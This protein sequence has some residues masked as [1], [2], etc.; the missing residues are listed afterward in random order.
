MAASALLGLG[1]NLGDRRAILRR[2]LAALAPLGQVAATSPVYETA[3]RAVVDQP[4][5]LNMAAELLTD[6][7]PLDL[8]HALKAIEGDLGRIP[9]PRFGPRSIDLD[10]LLFADQVIDLPALQVPHPRLAERAFALRPLADI[11][12]ARRHPLLGKTVAQL[13]AEIGAEQGV[14]R[15]ADQP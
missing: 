14:L 7:L 9:G 1:G 5:F 4:P 12:L 13:L 6:L 15:L 11:A 8:L 3:P 10:I 2:A